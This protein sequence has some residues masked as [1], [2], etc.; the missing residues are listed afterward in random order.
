MDYHHYGDH[1]P[2]DVAY[3]HNGYHY[4]HGGVY[5]YGVDHDAVVAVGYGH[6]MLTVQKQTPKV[7]AILLFFSQYHPK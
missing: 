4:Y 1:C 7:L 2:H 5:H 6:H 3:Y